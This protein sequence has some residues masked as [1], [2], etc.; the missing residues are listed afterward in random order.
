[1]A[2]LSYIVILH[3][4]TT[5]CWVMRNTQS[6]HISLFY[7]KPQ[8]GD[9]WFTGDVSCHI[10]LFYIKP[11]RFSGCYNVQRVV[12]YRYS[13]S[14]HNYRGMIACMT[15]LSYIVI[16]HQTT[17]ERE[18][19]TCRWKLS[20]IVILHQTTTH[21]HRRQKR[22]KLSYIVI[23]HQTTTHR[24]LFEKAARLSYIVILH[25]TTTVATWIVALA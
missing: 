7:I 17:T 18:A 16:L 9:S 14:N 8:L 2:A 21:P 6:C 23:L 20:Y 3:Q 19:T 10:S 12:I 25:Q 24:G 22:H 4:T 1:M 5:L 13:T 11:Q 15:R